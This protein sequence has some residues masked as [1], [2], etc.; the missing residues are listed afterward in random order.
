M[1]LHFGTSSSRYNEGYKKTN[2]SEGAIALIISVF[3]VGIFYIVYLILKGIYRLIVHL[4]KRVKYGKNYK[5]NRHYG[6]V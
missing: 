3:T 2:L 6:R 1:L 4:Y 5:N